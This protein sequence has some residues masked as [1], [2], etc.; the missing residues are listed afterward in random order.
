MFFSRF[1]TWAAA[2]LAGH[3]VTAQL[4]ESP[5]KLCYDAPGSSPQNVIVDDI[6]FVAS[7]LRAYGAQTRAGRQFTMTAANAPDCAVSCSGRS[8]FPPVKHLGNTLPVNE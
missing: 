1:I 2:I 3:A 7:Y 4:C 5:T 6:Q 8:D